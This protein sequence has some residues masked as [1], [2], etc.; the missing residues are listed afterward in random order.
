VFTE[1]VR[2]SVDL[3]RFPLLQALHVALPGGIREERAIW[4]ALQRLST[5]GEE[6][7]DLSYQHDAKGG[8]A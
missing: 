7:V 4:N 2:S 6:A 8:G 1:L 5:F 3:Y